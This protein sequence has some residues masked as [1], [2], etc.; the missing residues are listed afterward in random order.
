MNGT[1]LFGFAVMDFCK[2]GLRINIVGKETTVDEYFMLNTSCTLVGNNTKKAITSQLNVNSIGLAS[3]LTIQDLAVEFIGSKQGFQ[4]QSGTASLTLRNAT[5]NA[6]GAAGV[7]K[8]IPSLVLE[9]CEILTPK[10]AYYDPAKKYIVDES[11]NRVT[12]VVTIGQKPVVEYGIRIDDETVTEENCADVLGNGTISYDAAKNALR[13]NNAKIKNIVFES[14][15]KSGVRMDVEGTANELETI[16]FNVAGSISGSNTDSNVKSAIKIKNT[17]SYA[18]DMQKGGDVTIENVNLDID[19]AV[20]VGNGNNVLTLRNATVSVVNNTAGTQ[21]FKDLANIVFEDCYRYSPTES[22]FDAEQKTYLERDI[23]KEEKGKPLTKHILIVPGQSLYGNGTFENPYI[24]EESNMG[25]FLAPVGDTVYRFFPP[26]NKCVFSYSTELVD[27]SVKVSLGDYFTGSENRK[28]SN[29]WLYPGGLTQGVYLF[30]DHNP[31]IENKVTISLSEPAEGESTEKAIPLK[32]GDKFTIPEIGSNASL[33]IYYKVTLPAKHTVYVKHRLPG[34]SCNFSFRVEGHGEVGVAA[35]YIAS[36]YNNSDEPQEVFCVST[37]HPE[38][39]DATIQITEGLYDIFFYNVN[40]YTEIHCTGDNYTDILG[41]GTASYDPTTKVLTLN[42]VNMKDYALYFDTQYKGYRE[43]FD[44][45]KIKLVG[46]NVLHSMVEWD[47][48]WTL[49]GEGNLTLYPET[50]NG[51]SSC[52]VTIEDCNVEII[53]AKYSGFARDCSVTIRNANVKITSSIENVCVKARIFELEGCRIVSPEGAYFDKDK[54]TVVDKDGNPVT[55]ELIIAKTTTPEKGTGTKDDPFVLD[56]L[57]PAP[58]P[59][60]G[61]GTPGTGPGGTGTGKYTNPPTII[62]PPA[63]TSN[64]YTF[65]ATDDCVLGLAVSVGNEFEGKLT[66]NGND[67]GNIEDREVLLRKGNVVMLDIVNAGK[68][69]LVA[70]NLREVGEGEI[71]YK[72]IPLNKGDNAIAEVK[73]DKDLAMWYMVTLPDVTSLDLSFDTQGTATVFDSDKADNETLG[74]QV[75][76][77]GSGM[78]YSYAN[79]TNSSEDLYIK[80]ENMN[81]GCTAN[82]EFGGAVLG[83]GITIDGH[84]VNI[85]N[86]ADVLGDGTIS[87]DPTANVLTFNNA[88]GRIFVNVNRT[89]KFTSSLD[90]IKIKLIGDNTLFGLTVC[91]DVKSSICG[92]GTLFINN[93]ASLARTVNFYTEDD[94]IIEDCSVSMKSLNGFGLRVGT[95]SK[96]AKLT[97][98][99]ASLRIDS[100][101]DCLYETSDLLLE[102]CTILSPVGAHFDAGKSGIVG[103]DGELVKGELVIG[104]LVTPEK[105]TGTKEDPFKLDDK[106]PTPGTGGGEGEPGE[107]GGGGSTPIIIITPPEGSSFYTLTATGDCVLG[108]YANVGSEFKGTLSID[109]VDAG[110]IEDREILLHKDNVAMLEI[111]NAGKDDMIGIY[112]RALANGDIW[113]MPIE[114]VE[115]DNAIPMVVE[116]K[117]LAV[118]YKALIP[119]DKAMTIATDAKGSILTFS[120]KNAETQAAPVP[121][122]DNE[123]GLSFVYDNFTDKDIDRYFMVTSMPTACTATVSFTK[124]AGITDI[125]ADDPLT[126]SPLYN[127]SGQRVSTSYKGIVIRKG[128]KS[129]AK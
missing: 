57:L 32:N 77:D 120:A 69:D 24:I 93:T 72:A 54:E 128:R 99:N 40:D 28:R 103:D 79:T 114:L 110:N 9:D 51:F 33:P 37:S 92:N 86:H 104:K 67:A 19:G 15:C 4:S 3:S 95:L 30:I 60:P 71:W 105:G 82:V 61:P 47:I 106:L 11:G 76:A 87:Y 2:P 23:N 38:F 119:A 22:Y 29:R 63:G 18:I 117:N 55:G 68:D 124:S 116:G 16:S 34:Q 31:S 50:G 88:N 36:Y 48:P 73:K 90:G 85:E 1:H 64:C 74:I 56:D 121:L 97:I 5:V 7:F 46:N 49:Y 25:T 10:G 112:L 59:I 13:L 26:A 41:D 83:Y 14:N 58:S 12:G 43:M 109:G 96:H 66:I 80:V 17:T 91:G 89:E 115:G 100:P 70:L 84:E 98:R 65:T 125:T 45:F 127:I 52:K 81:A 78:K 39:Q 102:G 108:L 113:Y 75:E 118:W 107:E 126:S 94:L 44:G 6:N 42:N 35:R 20:C 62:T 21:L 123:T 8:Y 122:K 129:V 53:N 111:A 27:E 101:L